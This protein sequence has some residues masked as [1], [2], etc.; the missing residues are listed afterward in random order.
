M[1]VNGHCGLWRDFIVDFG[2]ISLW[3]LAFW[4]FNTI[5]TKPS[6]ATNTKSPYYA[7]S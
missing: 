4:R 7:A 5:F 6:F 1:V 2:M 3:A